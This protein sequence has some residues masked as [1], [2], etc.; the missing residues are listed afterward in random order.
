MLRARDGK[1]PFPSRQTSALAADD[2]A[3]LLGE[4]APDARVL[5]GV[6]GEL[7]ALGANQALTADLPRLFELEEG[8][9][10]GP[11]REEQLG[12]RVAAECLISPSVVGCSQGKA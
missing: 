11:D 8:K 7:E 3:L 1:V 12:V 10:G 2:P 6:E 4:S 9:S 5:I